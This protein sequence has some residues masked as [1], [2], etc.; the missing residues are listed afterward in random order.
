MSDRLHERGR[1]RSRVHVTDGKRVGTVFDNVGGDL[2]ARSLVATRPFGRMA[3]IVPPGGD[4]CG[5]YM[6]NL[7]LYGILLTRER[8]RPEEMRIVIEQGNCVRWSP[9]ASTRTGGESASAIVLRTW[10]R[11][12]R[13]SDRVKGFE[14]GVI[15]VPAT[16]LADDVQL[17]ARGANL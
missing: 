14:F 4:L 6:R 9:G 17:S 8:Q 1:F 3:C 5:L 12:D 10:P 7:T 15:T 16:R 2:I 13:A 11:Q